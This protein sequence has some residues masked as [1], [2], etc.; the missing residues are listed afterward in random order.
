MVP[1]KKDNASI[2]AT[3]I[4]AV[5]NF[6]VNMLLIPG[7]GAMGAVY[8]TI[9]TE[10]IVSV[11]HILYSYKYIKFAPIFKSLIPFLAPS[12]IMVVI[13]RMIG[14]M[15]GEKVITIIIQ[16]SVG[17]LLFI[18]LTIAILLIQKDE[19]FVSTIDSYKR[20]FKKNS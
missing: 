19:Y 6:T 17:G 8:A 7:F 11:I 4:G 14:K 18:I 15:L 12:A 3:S 13:V 9:L 5:I 10:I 20:K 2:V 1:N 16:V